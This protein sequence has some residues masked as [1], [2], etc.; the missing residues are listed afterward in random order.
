M[1]LLRVSRRSRG[2]VRRLSRTEL[3]ACLFVGFLVFLGIFGAWIAPHDPQATNLMDAS[4]PPSAEHWL[5]TDASGRDVLSRLLAGARTSLLGPLV[6]CL[7]AVG[8]GVGIAL[9]AVWNGGWA[10]ALLARI[11]D[12]GFA[13]P[14][15][16]LAILVVSIA[17]PGEWSAVVAI[18]L[19]TVP[20]VA[21]LLRTVALRERSMAYVSAL[22]LQGAGG[23]RICLL[24]LVPNMS[25]LIVA[26]ATLGFGYAM[27]DLAAVSYL[28]L[29]A[30]QPTAD[31]GLML[32]S[33][34]VGL[35]SGSPYEVFAAL[36]AILVCVVAVN[37]LGERMTSAAHEER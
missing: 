3:I 33:G 17:G 21:R 5:G 30:Q 20:Y 15:I 29:G 28:G 6:C 26:Q 36:T 10:D 37:V 2:R 14:S 1:A 19:A 9:F 4:L 8:L 13:F 11:L 24:H 22:E 34:Q 31:W 32:S 16:L 12:V 18:G 7:I 25:R 35:L 27:V 23:I